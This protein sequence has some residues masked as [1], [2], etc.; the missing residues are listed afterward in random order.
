[1][2]IAVRDGCMCERKENCKT[3]LDEIDNGIKVIYRLYCDCRKKGYTNKSVRVITSF[4][5]RGGFTFH[6]EP[7]PSEF[8]VIGGI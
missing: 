8:P 2:E 7:K 6:D 3:H 4:K 1:M 5:P